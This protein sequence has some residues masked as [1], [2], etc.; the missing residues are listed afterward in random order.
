MNRKMIFYTIG[1]IIKLEGFLLLLPLIVSLIY[2]DGCWWSFLTVSAG[3][4]GVGY[5]LTYFCKTKN[6]VI[7]AKE[8]FV[9]V[10]L[11]W[12]LLSLTGSLPFCSAVR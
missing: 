8:G 5:V 4:I 9:I 11:S 12:I 10:G 1:Q 2:K 6:Q 7:F 3:A